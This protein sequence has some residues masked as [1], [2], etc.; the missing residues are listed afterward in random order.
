MEILLGCLNMVKGQARNNGLELVTDIP[1]PTAHINA[2]LR[3]V[4]Q[5]L[6]NMLSNAVK[7]TPAGGKVTL[8]AWSRPESGHVFQVIDTGIGIALEDVPKIMQPFAQIES[9]MSRKHQGTGLG[10]PLIKRLAEMH[11]GSVDIQSA[12]GAGTTVTVRFP[13]ERM[14]E[15]PGSE[16]SEESASPEATEAP[17]AKDSAA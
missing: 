14:V 10:L 16:E 3:V 6:I 2:D 15:T 9:A 11:G 13:P 17:E 7:F 8:K 4:K 5:I 12:L 1:E